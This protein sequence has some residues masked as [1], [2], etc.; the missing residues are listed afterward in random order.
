[1]TF[2][3]T[4][5]DQPDWIGGPGAAGDALFTATFSS[6]GE[7]ISGALLASSS[8]SIM[9]VIQA[10]S[11]TAVGT[12]Q[13]EYFETNAT[14]QVGIIQSIFINS[15]CLGA[16]IIPNY[17]PIFEIAFGMSAVGPQP[18][19]V[20][21]SQCSI[22]TDRIIG[23][24]TGQISCGEIAALAA[25]SSQTFGVGSITAGRAHFSVFTTSASWSAE[26]FGQ[27]S[28]TDIFALMG[29]SN[30]AISESV[31]FTL[32][33]NGASIAFTNNSAAAALFLW[34]LTVD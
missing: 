16:I 34:S 12:I 28:T 31:D 26:V 2:A 19:T 5:S 17:T 25:H 32:P 7:I 6:P 3:Q 9:V 10:Q 4:P 13:I 20:S 21:V 1:M 18:V 24:P 8:P 23:F 22:A 33:P 30:G 29:S 14:T 15:P 11:G 27:S